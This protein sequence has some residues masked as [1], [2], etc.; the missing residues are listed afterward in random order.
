MRRD[1]EILSFWFGE[2]TGPYDVGPNPKKWWV[3]D[4]AFDEEIR[5]RF[6]ADVQR[7]AEGAYDDWLG[8]PRSALGLVILLDQFP[9]NIHRGS[10]AAWSH[11][12][13]A[14]ATSLEAVKRG[15][16]RPL[17]VVE[18]QF[19][20]MPLMHSERLEMH[21]R[22][23]E[24]IDATLRDVPEDAL[25]PFA[26]WRSAAERHREIVERFGRYPHRNEVL[27]RS[28]TAEERAFLK[29]PNSSF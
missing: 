22:L 16:D 27:G 28:S 6:G 2:L 12:D 5:R 18:R 15:H 20:Y 21:E 17:M 7:A 4:D 11:D 8:A 25:G 1:E 9:R 14:L 29:E 13:Q 3:K 10:S 26:S 19:L 23:A 24:L